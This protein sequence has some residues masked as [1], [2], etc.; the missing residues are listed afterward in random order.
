[1]KLPKWLRSVGKAVGEAL[2]G[3]AFDRFRKRW[4]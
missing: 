1:V 2:L 4:K 3:W